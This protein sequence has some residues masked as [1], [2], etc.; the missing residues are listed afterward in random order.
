MPIL[1][2]ARL[3]RRPLLRVWSINRKEVTETIMKTKTDRIAKAIRVV[4]RNLL[5]NSNTPWEEHAP[6]VENYWTHQALERLFVK[7]QTAADSAKRH[8]ITGRLEEFEM[9]FG[10]YKGQRLKNVPLRYLDETICS[11]P[12]TWFIR[13]VK[14]YVDMEMSGLVDY[15]HFKATKCPTL[16]GEEYRDAQRKKGD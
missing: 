9:P 5:K 14:N 16:S 3:S 2:R 12:E 11:M 1:W 4:I 7:L 13:Q 8:K 15:W 10:K 6:D